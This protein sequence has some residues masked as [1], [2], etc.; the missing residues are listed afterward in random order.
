MFCWGR[1]ASA[2]RLPALRHPDV[3]SGDTSPDQN[4]HLAV[5]DHGSNKHE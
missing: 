5:I 4:R 1:T 2:L 3:N